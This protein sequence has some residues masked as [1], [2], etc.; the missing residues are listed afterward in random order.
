MNKHGLVS[1]CLGGLIGGSALLWQPAT[2]LA[3]T[4]SSDVSLSQKA[5]VFNQSVESKPYGF[6]HNG[7]SY[8]PIWYV[9]QALK[10]LGID[11]SWNGKQLTLKT[12]ADANMTNLHPGQGTQDIV[13]NGTVVQKVT[14]ITEKD[15]LSGK[16][17]TYM[18]TWFV[19]QVLK[20]LNIESQ[21]NGTVWQFYNGSTPPS[22]GNLELN[23]NTRPP[24][25]RAASSASQLGQNIVNFAKKLIGVPY[26]YGGESTRGFDC[27]GFVQYVFKHFG[28]SLPRTTYAQARVG[29]AVSKST[30][31][32][33]DLVFFDTEGSA[34]S[35]V[36]I[37]VGDGKFI[38][39][40][41]S[42]GVQI[43]SLFSGYY[44][45]GRYTKAIDPLSS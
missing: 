27:S 35:H 34:F 30:L 2:A 32:P 11:C 38:S 8:M 29:S 12:T 41:S 36:G 17:T 25:S 14:G 28:K 6:V 23:L 13:L 37:Y 5:I 15:P 1:L 40:T 45:P 39:A 22:L 7:T 26:V 42:H 44:W 33:G 3:A 43:R 19:M 20:R 18:P 9:M 21:W 16:S 4:T 10:K 31:K 24:A